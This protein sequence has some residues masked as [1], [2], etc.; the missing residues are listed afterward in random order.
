MKQIE[1]EFQGQNIRVF[2]EKLG[3]ELWFH[4]NSRTC[5]VELKKSRTG[6]A[7]ENAGNG[8]VYAPMPG[9]V[10]KINIKS[11]QKVKKSELLV[12]MEAMKMEY[13][14]HA[15]FDG[16]VTELNCKVDDQVAHG[17]LLVK[18]AEDE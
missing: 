16:T 2:A 18:V 7:Q 6:S 13:S 4:Y 10:L 12:V 8:E 14:F 17:Q 5:M 3:N 9:K 11:G 1:I 15:D